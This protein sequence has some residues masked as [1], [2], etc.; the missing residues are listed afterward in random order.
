[1][2][3]PQ[4]PES[5]AAAECCSQH[6]AG[7]HAHA[8]AR[9]DVLRIA[10]VAAAA[11]FVGLGV[12]ADRGLVGLV[13]IA[14]TL[15]GGLPILREAWA[16]IT[17][18]RMTMELSMTIALLAALA[19]GEFLTV[20]V[21]VLFV[22]VAEEL[23]KL[24]V[25]RGRR[26]IADLLAFLPRRVLV[27]RG[28]DVVDVASAEV[29]RGDVIVVKPGARIPVDGTVVAGASAVDQA[30][31]TG[32]SLPV[33][34]VAGATVFAGTINRTGTLDVRTES[35]G[36]DTTFGRIIDAVERA[37]RTRAPIQKTAD[38]LA[39]WLVYFT[40]A[41]AVA[42][43][44]LTR[45]ARATI[46]VV[47]V[48]GA[49]GIAAGTPL[50]ILGAIGRAAH[51]GAIIKGGIALEVLGRA[52]TIVLD[53]T[54]TLTFGR[55]EVI[56]IRSVAGAGET[57]VLAAAATAELASEH[58]LAGAVLARAKGMAIADPDGFESFPGRGVRAVLDGTEILVGSRAWLAERGIATP[59]GWS[60]ADGTTEIQVARAGSLLGAIAARD[61]LRPEAVAAV[62]ALR[63]MGMRIV[64]LT[65][66]A[67]GIAAAIGREL[68]VHEV[69]AELLP[70]DKLARV[71]E[72]ATS[73]RTVAVVGDGVNDAPALVEAAVGIAMGSGTDV[74][75]ECADV[76]LIGDDLLKLVETVRL[77]RRC[78]R[79][80]H[81]NFAGTIAVD[82]TGMA[83]A[84]AGMLSP[85][86]AAVIHVGS[87]L[88][89]ILNSARLLTR[90][91]SRVLDWRRSPPVRAL[92][93]RA[94][95]GHP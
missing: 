15:V 89:F 11:A 34:K 31:I 80:I 35:L 76:V 69:E 3:A 23:E 71:R 73:G 83:L 6:E 57:D 49:C 10:C 81:A 70:Q 65:G 21:I 58:A 47:V 42:T 72:L 12:A 78:R 24:T 84:A 88:A 82:L 18:R 74:A 60:V 26:A 37:E 13:A 51:R 75:R 30:A 29:G 5:A 46:S 40:L 4:E 86:L 16:A 95:P 17:V 85:I 25:S 8:F 38:R 68:G 48:A 56:A 94:M 59:T 63:A 28:A 87:E 32:E 77:A 20:L 14:V 39:R 64:L 93:A 7:G 67:R 90:S 19:I 1:M 79:I 53:K 45:D 22:L 27:R 92:S 41:G 2:M 61:I 50:A 43:A 62:A 52:D 36:R 44:L 9:G 54:G 55:P 91:P 66:D 33:E